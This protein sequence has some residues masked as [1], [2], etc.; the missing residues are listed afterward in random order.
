MSNPTYDGNKMLDALSGFENDDVLGY[1]VRELIERGVIKGL[2]IDAAAAKIVAEREKDL[3]SNFK[4][5]WKPAT[6]LTP[7]VSTPK[8]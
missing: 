8:L 3:H 7:S 5:A 6:A 4:K 1:L 2:Q